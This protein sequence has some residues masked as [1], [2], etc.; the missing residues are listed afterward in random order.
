MTAG[1]EYWQKIN[2]CCP[3]VSGL[4][5][6]SRNVRFDLRFSLSSTVDMDKPRELE[7]SDTHYV[8]PG[9]NFSWP[10]IM[11]TFQPCVWIYDWIETHLY[12]MF[13]KIGY[14]IGYHSIYGYTWVKTW[15]LNFLR[16]WAGGFS[17]ISEL[18]SFRPTVKILICRFKISI[19][20]LGT[21]RKIPGKLQNF[22]G[23]FPKIP[24]KIPQPPPN[25][26][27]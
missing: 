5:I 12:R 22:P 21:N 3:R 14:Q 16:Y 4:R 24:S 7:W 27:L 20:V 9:Y 26:H 2:K 19:L 8:I 25:P 15:K 23:K 13:W 10:H 6:V 11:F 17:M 1:V 18:F